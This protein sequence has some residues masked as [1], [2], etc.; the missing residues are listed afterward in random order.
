MAYST[1]PIPTIDA[2]GF[3]LPAF[4][5]VLAAHKA[6]Y[7]GIYGQDVDLSDAADQDVEWLSIEAFAFQETFALALA[8]YNSFSPVTAQGTGLSSVVKVNGITRDVAS[9]ST[10]T[11]TIIGQAGTV[12]N[13]TT[14]GDGVNAW[15]LPSPVV[16]PLSGT[17]AVTATCTVLGAVTVPQ[18]TLGAMLNPTY[19]LQSIA[20]TGATAPGQP[21]ETDPQLKTRQ[22][23]STTLPA[24]G[25]VDGI[26]G[27]I[28]ALPNAVRARVYENDGASTDARGIPGHSISAV[29]D[30]GDNGAIANAIAIRKLSSGT[31]G[32]S[33]G[34]VTTGVAGIP[35]TIYFFR[36]NEPPITVA[37]GVKALTGFTTD[38]QAAIQAAV[39]SYI[40]RLGIGDGAL[41]SI[42]IG[43]LYGPALLIGTPFA[44]TFTITSLTI[45][46]DGGTPGIAAVPIGFNEAPQ[47]STA[48]VTVTPS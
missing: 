20:F 41:G 40:N 16:I 45:A 5:E 12:L 43:R 4:A 37:I 30:G 9:Y 3:H 19:G 28:L 48:W 35:R 8:V 1:V 18:G 42:D 7:Q 14:V 36:P 46:R 10:Q 29:V 17:I 6:D 27:A 32:T 22:A 44:G 21:V 38:A 26:L 34:V 11:V 15:A 23:A 47:T 31:Y 2:V 39:A 13:G 24:V 25:L 33:S